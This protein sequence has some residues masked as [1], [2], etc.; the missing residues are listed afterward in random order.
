MEFLGQ[1]LEVELDRSALAI[2]KYHPLRREE[3]SKRKGG[4]PERRG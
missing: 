1:E 4:A 2:P 3:P